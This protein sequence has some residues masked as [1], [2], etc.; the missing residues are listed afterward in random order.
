MKIPSLLLLSLTAFSALPAAAEEPAPG[1]W[2][3]NL[4][5]A[6][7]GPAPQ[8]LE[9]ERPQPPA[10]TFDGKRRPG[11]GRK[12]HAHTVCLTGADDPNALFS[13]PPRHPKGDRTGLTCAITYS[14]Q[15]DG[16]ASWSQT[17]ETPMGPR[18]AEGQAQFSAEQYSA[19]LT[20]AA[21]AERPARTLTLTAKRMGDCPT[22]TN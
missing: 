19:N 12:G 5:P 16:T 3:I 15:T 9:G 8:G 10:A 18:G 13:Q 11:F 2:Q 22:Q 20:L 1:L 4:Q 21:E 7:A 6:E 17:C 14:S